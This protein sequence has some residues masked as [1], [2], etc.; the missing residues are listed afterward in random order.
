MQFNSK[1]VNIVPNICFFLDGRSY[2][3]A[4]DAHVHENPEWEKA[5]QALA[6]INKNQ[7]SAKNT[8]DNRNAAEV[9]AS[10]L[11]HFTR[12]ALQNLITYG[13]NN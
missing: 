12:S 11:L 3:A 13:C 2:G 7:T 8:Q 5:R 4:A 1:S 9:C 6:S 10:S